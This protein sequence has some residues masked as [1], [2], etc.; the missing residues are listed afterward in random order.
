RPAAAPPPGDLIRLSRNVAGDSKPIVI[1]ADEAAA[2]YEGQQLVVL[3]H[4][5]VLVQQGVVQVR[6]QDAVGWVGVKRYPRS[7]VPHLDLYAD[8][9]VRL[10]L[11]SEIR[12]GPKGLLELNTRGEFKLNAHKSPVVRQRLADDPVYRRAVEERTRPAPAP[13]PAPAPVQRTGHRT[14]ERD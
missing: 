14:S 13:P 5:Q 2:W 10:D 1:D 6:S 9:G 4:G 12:D 7:G 8:G 3:L 11:S